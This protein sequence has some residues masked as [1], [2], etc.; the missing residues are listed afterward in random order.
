MRSVSV[1]DVVVMFLKYFFFVCGL[2]SCLAFKKNI[3][4][5]QKFFSIF[6]ILCY[7]YNSKAARR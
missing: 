2:I 7:L 1:F 6:R 3:T 5:Y 4:W